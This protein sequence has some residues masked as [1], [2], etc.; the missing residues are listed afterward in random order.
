MRAP[1]PLPDRRYSEPPVRPSP[2]DPESVEGKKLNEVHQ[3][4]AVDGYEIE[5]DEGRSPLNDE[6]KMYLVSSSDSARPGGR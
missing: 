5:S 2:L 1:I 4:F 6:E 3:H